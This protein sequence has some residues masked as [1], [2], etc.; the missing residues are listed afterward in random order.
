MRMVTT[1]TQTGAELLP[2]TLPSLGFRRKSVQSQTYATQPQPMSLPK[3]VARTGSTTNQCNIS[4][5]STST[6]TPLPSDTI[7]ASW[8]FENTFPLCINEPTP[9]NKISVDPGAIDLSGNQ[10]EDPNVQTQRRGQPTWSP[11]MRVTGP[12]LQVNAS[13]LQSEVVLQAVRNFSPNFSKTARVCFFDVVIHAFL[14]IL[15]KNADDVDNKSHISIGGKSYAIRLLNSTDRKK[16]IKRFKQAE[17]NQSGL[18]S[19]VL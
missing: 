3:S 2:F 15:R 7:S 18:G 4:T 17:N 10:S 13:G 6:L 14:V 8:R 11:S 16:A 5:I 9:R 1:A 12:V 19:I